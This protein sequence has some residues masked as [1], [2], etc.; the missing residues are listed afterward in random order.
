MIF[1]AKT[2]TGSCR[3]HNE[4]CFGSYISK[5]GQTLFFVIAD[6]MGGHNAGEVAS[7]MLV[8]FFVKRVMESDRGDWTEESLK[9]LAVTAIQDAN[10]MI[11]QTARLDAGK[12]G[13]GTTAVV[14]IFYGD[15]LITANVG[16]SRAYISTKSKLIRITQD[17]SFVEDLL[18]QGAIDS[19][20][21]K[22]H[23]DRNLIT[24]AVGCTEDV[25][26]DVFVTDFEKDCVLLMC[27]DGLNS[28]VDD[29]AMQRVIRRNKNMEKLC[30]RLVSMAMKN[31]GADNITVVVARRDSE[32]IL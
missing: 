18:R 29:D 10:A 17:H 16:D 27:S 7:G 4:D 30:D 31:G 3:P 32:V 12:Y 8:D 23:P 15:K 14:C 26:V 22:R 9:N 19:K 24:R 6:G 2:D 21:A 1:C 11:L 5:D 13:M 28:M 20:E 25:Q